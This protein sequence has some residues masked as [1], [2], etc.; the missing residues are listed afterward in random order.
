MFV[1]IQMMTR[2]MKKYSSYKRD[3]PTLF[4]PLNPSGVNHIHE[5][6]YC[7]NLFHFYIFY[8]LLDKLFIFILCFVFYL[9]MLNISS[10]YQANRS[11]MICNSQS[12]L[13]LRIIWVAPIFGEN[14]LMVKLS[15]VGSSE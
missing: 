9:S 1:S 14:V 10:S 12:T 7:F 3:H 11:I 8:V 6:L 2:I 5:K 4:R 15:I 13:D